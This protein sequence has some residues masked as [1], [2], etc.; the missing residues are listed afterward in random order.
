MD[1]FLTYGLFG[2]RVSSSPAPQIYNAFFDEL[3]LPAVYMPF[4][5]E[6][7]RFITA[8]PVLRSEFAGFNVDVPYQLDIVVHIDTLD[9]TVKKIG[10]VNT[11]KVEDGKLIGYNT[12][13][14]AFERS[15]VGFVGNLYDK[16]VLLIGS[17]GAAHTA[18]NVLL[19][20]GAFLSIL[21]RNTANV[22]MLKERLQSKF[23][24]NR[25]RILNEI[26]DTTEFYAVVNA[27]GIDIEDKQSKISIKD[28]TYKNFRFVYDFNYGETDFLKKASSFGA[29]TKDGLDMLF[30]Q[31]VGALEVW[32]GKGKFDVSVISNVYD[33][34]KAKL[35]INKPV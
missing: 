1:D 35:Q 34:I 29:N 22:T 2:E 16:E 20:R 10:A 33:T 28:S 11:V 4:A 7:E 32:L 17:G 12:E 30:Y 6:K 14:S 19:G 15:L 26:E 18:A 8:L 27:T 5:V 21:S 13:S 9:E 3:H 23:N 24:K 31:S 25:I